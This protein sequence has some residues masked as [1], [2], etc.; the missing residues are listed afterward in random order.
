MPYRRKHK[1]SPFVR[2]LH[3]SQHHERPIQCP[4]QRL[5]PVPEHGHGTDR[6]V[7]GK[8]KHHQK[9]AAQHP[10]HKRR[11]FGHSVQQLPFGCL[12]PAIPVQPP[13]A[14]PGAE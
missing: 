7:N 14:R 2:T 10:A 12:A 3:P 8:E 1:P 5:I 4:A 13:S 11:R 6:P 9:R